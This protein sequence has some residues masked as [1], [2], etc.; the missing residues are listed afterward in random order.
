MKRSTAFGLGCAFMA[1]AALAF[2]AGL[3]TARRTVPEHERGAPV[4]PG[5]AELLNPY[6]PQITSDPYFIEQQR[7]SLEAL[8]RSCRASGTYCR[9]A[10]QMRQLLADRGA[11]P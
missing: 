2:P 7:K 10:A 1:G 9:E 4:R 3:F 6:S 11:V 8:E 5:H